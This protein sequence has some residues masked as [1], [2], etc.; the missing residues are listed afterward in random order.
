MFHILVIL[1][2][3][4]AALGQEMETDKVVV[5]RQEGVGAT[6]KAQPHFWT[7]VTP[8]H[9]TMFIHF[10]VAKGHSGITDPKLDLIPFTC[11]QSHTDLKVWA[12][13]VVTLSMFLTVVAGGTLSGN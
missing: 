11:F 10:E 13:D 3:I 2:N 1:P 9:R 8:L 4:V 6:D 12:S 5:L 7:A